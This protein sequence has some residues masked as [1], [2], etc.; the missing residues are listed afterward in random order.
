V[1]IKMLFSGESGGQ[2]LVVANVCVSVCEREC[3]RAGE[4]GNGI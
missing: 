2:Q 4:V 1:T 3:E